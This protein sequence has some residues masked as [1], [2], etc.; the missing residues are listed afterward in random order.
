MLLGERI[1]NIRVDALLGTGGMGEVYRGFDV[2]LERHVAIKTLRTNHRLDGEISAR[3]LREARILSRL[4]SSSICQVYD[5]IADED[6]DYLIF[7]YVEGETLRQL[8][9]RRRLS[10]VAA[11]TLAEKIT[12]ALAVAH[13]ECIV[14]RDLKPEN[15]MVTPDGEVK[16]LDF[17]ISSVVRDTAVG[18]PWQEQDAR[19]ARR[20]PAPPELPQQ[21]PEHTHMLTEVMTEHSAQHLG[22]AA[23]RPGDLDSSLEARLTR[24]GA[25]IGTPI[26]MSPEQ[27][28]GQ[29]VSA[30][31]DMFAFGLLLQEMLTGAPAREAAPLRRL[32]SR[33]IEGKTRP[34]RD[35]EIDPDTVRLVEDLLRFDPQSRPSAAEAAE[36]LRWVLDRPKRLQLQKRRNLLVT[37]AFIVLVAV[38]TVVS[39][40]ALRADRSAH[41]AE[42]EAQRAETE[43]RRANAQAARANQEASRAREVADF[44]VDLFE[45][46]SPEQALGQEVGLREILERG[47]QRIDRE[48]RAQPLVRARLQDTL[49]T[50]HWR[51]GDYREAERLLTEALKIR[52]EHL[53]KSSPERVQSKQQLAALFADQG[54]LE[55][56]EPLLRAAIQALEGTESSALPILAGVLN[57]LAA[58]LFERGE[59][60]EAESLYQQSLGATERAFGRESIEFGY[61]LNNLAVLAWQL[62]DHE[63]AGALYEQSLAIQEEELGKNHPNLAA[64]L[65]NLGIL[66]REMNELETAEHLHT[67]ALDIA[68]TTLGEAHPDVAAILDSLGRLLVLRD[69]LD[70]ALPLF[71]RAYAIRADVLGPDSH[72]V[73]RTLTTFGDLLRRRGELER[74]E[75]ML[76]RSHRL[77]HDALG[78]KHPWTLEATHALANA[79]RDSGERSKAASLYRQALT[80]SVNLLGADHPE[81]EAIRQD[82]RLLRQEPSPDP[83]A[84]S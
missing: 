40:L 46:A 26:F 39:V 35:S 45:A 82:Q 58:L 31:S 77:L 17:G 81:V 76:R 49:G 5:L 16:I 9:E 32:L 7:E 52:R 6:T 44:L 68:E 1:G 41:R 30:A 70:D 61:R 3:F 66:H 20:D 14:H 4:E 71:E 67:R 15:V 8:L 65:N 28:A 75:S 27:A 80:A 63:R 43:A 55:V 48:L 36:R 10:S 57:D 74:A 23:A 79:Y 78:G 62:G 51:L 38:L 34:I 53:A 73:G 25:M 24:N 12:R 60:S 37:A 50:I 54:R 2:R 19:L 11:L 72:E 29:D 83:S 21:D 47:S 18:S 84:S 13:A 33:V 22:L 56:A 64:L 42:E 59:F 69:R